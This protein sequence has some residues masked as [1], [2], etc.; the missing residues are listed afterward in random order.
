LEE[1]LVSR[2]YSV[3]PFS[4]ASHAVRYLE[5]YCDELD[6][7]ITDQAMPE[8]SGLEL[9]AELYQRRPELPVIVCTGSNHDG[10]YDLI[11]SPSIKQFLLKPIR[12]VELLQAVKRHISIEL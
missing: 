8:V 11:P 12:P 2:G 5:E 10:Y 4:K 1:L 7:V 6:M 3:V 9:A